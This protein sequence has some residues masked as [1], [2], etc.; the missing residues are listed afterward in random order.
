M[1]SQANNYHGYCPSSCI[2]F[3]SSEGKVSTFIIE[4]AF[5]PF[6]MSAVLVV[7]PNT[8]TPPYGRTILKI[9]D[10]RVLTKRRPT[11]AG[12]NAGTETMERVTHA[13]RPWTLELEQT[14]ASAREQRKQAG[15]PAL[16][17]EECENLRY[18]EEGDPTDPVGKAN[19]ALAFEEYFYLMSMDYF[20]D[21]RTAYSVLADLQGS[22]IPKLLAVGSICFP[23]EER[24]IEPPALLLEY[25][26]GVTLKHA[27]LSLIQDPKT[28][29]A[30]LV[31]AIDSL[32][33]RGFLHQDLNRDNIL[34]SSVHDPQRAILIDFGHS[35]YRNESDWIEAIKRS[36]ESTGIR[37]ILHKQLP[38]RMGKG[39]WPAP[40]WAQIRKVQAQ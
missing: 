15:E 24:A 36:D 38:D 17:I 32:A 35:F 2:Q 8:D 10:P 3:K 9:Y 19:Q 40:P 30:P 7:R 26:N 18:P 12:P 22:V 11:P 23:E 39:M 33:P 4:K 1:A 28:L 34:L 14:A 6:T 31:D 27:D 21:E 37:F 25:I 29:F 20:D 5:V 13:T 16:S